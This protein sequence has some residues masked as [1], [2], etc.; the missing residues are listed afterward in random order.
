MA[1]D[2]DLLVVG[3]RVFTGS[4]ERPWARA[5][6]IGG[7]RLL[8]VGTESQAARRSGR[9]TGRID[10]RGRTVVPGFIDAHAH[11]SDAAGELGWTRLG[12]ERAATNN[13][14]RKI[15]ARCIPVC[16]GSDGMPYG[17]LYGIHSAV[18]GFFEDQRI[19]TED[20]FRAATAGGAHASFEEGLK[21]TLEAG[22]LADFAILDRDPFGEPEQIAGIRVHSTWIGGQPVYR[23]HGKR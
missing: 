2:A 17:P 5:F 8:A 22:K 3:A 7:D 9:R 21:G 13:P 12:G 18:N 23:S 19:S 15:L 6:A 16:F 20:A 4:R 1:G 10:L 14:Y 11:L